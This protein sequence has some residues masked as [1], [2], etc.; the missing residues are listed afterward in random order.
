MAVRIVDLP[1]SDRPRER[2]ARFG[3]DGLSERELIALVI[4]TGGAGA[5]ALDVAAE[6][7]SSRG[8]LDALA[9]ARLEDLMSFASLGDA[10]AASLLSSFELGR[11]ALAC[12]NSRNAIKKPEDLVSLVKPMLAGKAHEEVVLVVMNAANGPIRMLPLTRGGADGCLIPVRDVLSAVL[13]NDGV[14]FALAH[15]HPSGVVSP[16]HEDILATR[17]IE[18]GAEAAGLRFVDHII[19]GQSDWISVRDHEICPT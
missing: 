10:K 4:R 19:V 7:L 9:S 15:N 2:L 14:A 17:R 6:I 1:G 11:R 3:L 13:R 8:S 16:S 18:D 5:S 12:S